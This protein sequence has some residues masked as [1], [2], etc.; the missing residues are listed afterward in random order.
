MLGFAWFACHPA[1]SGVLCTHSTVL[2]FIGRQTP[3]WLQGDK[4]QNFQ[5][6][7]PFR[8]VVDFFFFFN[9][10]TSKVCCVFSAA[11]LLPFD[12]CLCFLHLCSGKEKAEVVVD[13][14][15]SLEV[16]EIP[17]G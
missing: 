3:D 6:Y 7:L 9:M 17:G 4:T 8:Q 2:L 5:L 14:A 1:L 12:L 13:Q 10:N 15:C 16:A 11:G